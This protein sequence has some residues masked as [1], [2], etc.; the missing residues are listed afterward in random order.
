MPWGLIRVTVWMQQTSLPP[1]N[2]AGGRGN[3]TEEADGSPVQCLGW[4]SVSK[5]TSL[6]NYCATTARRS[7]ALTQPT[8][9]KSKS[10]F[11]WSVCLG[12]DDQQQRDR[13]RFECAGRVGSHVARAACDGFGVA[14][15]IW[16]GE[17]GAGADHCSPW[18]TPPGLQSKTHCSLSS[19]QKKNKRRS[20]S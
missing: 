17:R 3:V 1:T 15:E 2:K 16:T 18:S 20:H 6:R 7:H 8:K 9:L 12:S 4:V 19:R 5:H 10:G 11:N 13:R 14:V